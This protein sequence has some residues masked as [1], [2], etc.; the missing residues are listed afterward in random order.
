MA[1]NGVKCNNRKKPTYYRQCSSN[2]NSML[3]F[4][5][6]NLIF[7]KFDLIKNDDIKPDCLAI[8]C[9]KLWKRRKPE[10][11][12]KLIL[13][14]AN[15]FHE[16]WDFENCSFS[17]KFIYHGIQ[18]KYIQNYI[19]RLICTNLEKDILINRSRQGFRMSWSSHRLSHQTLVLN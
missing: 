5:L 7:K 14:Q 9:T 2:F 11:N 19:Q 15:K 12:R 8:K 4:I 13:W 6:K 18:Q 3:F 17:L 16:H 1:L 10:I